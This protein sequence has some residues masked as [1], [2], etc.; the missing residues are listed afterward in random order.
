[1]TGTSAWHPCAASLQNTQRRALWGTPQPLLHQCW[2]CRQAVRRPRLLARSAATL[3]EVETPALDIAGLEGTHH[4]YQLCSCLSL[5]LAWV[6]PAH[7]EHH[8]GAAGQILTRQP[9]PGVD[10]N[11]KQYHI[12]TFGCQM[13]LADSERMAGVLDSAGYSCTEDPSEADVLIYNTCSIRDKAEQKVYSALGRQVGFQL[14]AGTIPGAILQRDIEKDTW[15]PHTLLPGQVCMPNPQ[16]CQ[17]YH[18]I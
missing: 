13:N 7:T 12:H 2:Q 14:Q 11:G 18:H 1:M 16:I 15:R 5:E 10:W 6:H 4:L 8:N 17:P 9:Q 3:Q